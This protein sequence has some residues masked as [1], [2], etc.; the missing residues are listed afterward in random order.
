MLTALFTKILFGHD[1]TE[2]FRRGLQRNPSLMQA[3]GLPP[4]SNSRDA[5]RYRVP[6]KSA[7]SRFQQQLASIDQHR[8]EVSVLFAQLLDKAKTRLPDL[9]EQLGFDGKRSNRI[10]PTATLI[11]AQKTARRAFEPGCQLGG[12]PILMRRW[13]GARK[14][15]QAKMVWL[16]M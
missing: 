13:A 3:C 14:S 16:F 1:S 15:H 4:L 6:S 9:G 8:G 11:A 2:S 10:P 7:F 12:A 5:N